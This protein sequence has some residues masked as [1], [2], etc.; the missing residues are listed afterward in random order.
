MLERLEL[1]AGI[2]KLLRLLRGH[3]GRND[4]CCDEDNYACAHHLTRT[5]SATA[6]ESEVCYHFIISARLPGGWLHRLVSCFACN[7]MRS[8]RVSN[9]MWAGRRA[10]QPRARA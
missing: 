8:G 6:G 2:A 9:R 1:T 3:K 5:S 4:N 10:A 7:G